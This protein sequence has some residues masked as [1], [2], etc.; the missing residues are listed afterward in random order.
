MS[1]RT[2]RAV[3]AFAV[4]V[5]GVAMACTTAGTSGGETTSSSSGDPGSSSSG[6]ST[7]STGGSSTSQSSGGTTSSSSSGGASSGLII[8]DP[9]PND[10]DNANKDSDCDGLTDEQEYG[11]TYAGGNRT[12]PA[13]PDT[14]GDG[15]LDGVEV[16]ST[17]IVSGDAQACGPFTGDAD[18]ATR[19]IPTEADSEADGVPDGREDLN[20]NGRLDDGET[21]PNNRDSD[22]DGLYDGLEDVNGNGVVDAGETSASL[23]DS[24]ADDIPDGVEDVNRDGT[25]QPTETDPRLADTDGDGLH[26]GDEDLNW[27]HVVDTGETDPLQADT[28]TDQDGIPDARETLLGYDIND[29]DMDDDGLEDGE[30]DRNSNGLVEAN[31]THPRRTDSDCD[32]L[33]DGEEDANHDGQLGADE[34]SPLA[35]DSDGDILRD[36]LE[37]GVTTNPD[38]TNCTSFTADVDPNTTTNARSADTDADGINDGI[39]DV[40]GDGARVDSETDPLNPDTDGD[41]LLDGA[42]DINDNHVVDVG[43]TNPLIPD[44]D[45]DGDGLPDSAEALLGTSPTDTDSDDDGILDGT[46]DKNHDGRVNVGETHPLSKDTDCDGVG[47]GEEDANKNGAVDSGETDPLNDDSDT[48]GITDGVELGKTTNLEPALCPG[49]LAAAQPATITNPLSEDSDGDGVPDGAEDANQNGRLEPGELNPNVNDAG[50]VIGEVCTLA[51]LTPIVFHNTEPEADIQLATLSSFG[52]RTDIIRL[53]NK[54][55]EVVVDTTASAPVVLFAF[56]RAPEADELNANAIA[57]HAQQDLNGVG[58]GVQNPITQALP[59]ANPPADCT[60]DGFPAVLGSYDLQYAG[61]AYDAVNTMIPRLLSGAAAPLTGAMG[62]TGPFKLRMEFVRRSDSRAVIL[63]AIMPLSIYN[64]VNAGYGYRLDD[65][66]NGSAL[67]QVGDDTGVQC[68]VFETQAYPKAD[69][70]FVIDNS[71]SMGDD[72]QALT[73]AADAMLNQ[74]QNAL[75]DWRV[76]RITTDTDSPHDSNQQPVALTYGDPANAPAPPNVDS[77]NAA[78]HHWPFVKPGAG[79]LDFNGASNVVRNYI[80]NP[81]IAGW[82]IEASFEPLRFVLQGNADTAHRLLPATAAGAPEDAWKLRAD[83]RLAVLVVSD[84]GE[85]SNNNARILRNWTEGN[86][87]TILRFMRGG[88]NNGIAL[89]GTPNTATY[90]LARQDEPAILLGGILCPLGYACSGEEGSTADSPL[91]ATYHNTVNALGGVVGSIQQT[92]S[93]APSVQAFMSAVI[94]NASPYR[95]TKAPISASIKVAVEGQ[96]NTG[97]D[98]DNIPRSRINGFDYDGATGQI[99]FYGTCRPSNE[100]ALIGQR[101]AVSYRY[102]IDKTDDP[103]GEPPPCGGQCEAPL[104]CNPTTNQCECPASCGLQNG[105]PAPQVCDTNVNVCACT[106]PADCGG[107]PPSPRLTCNT[108]TCQFTCPQDCGG[109]PPGEGFTC[110]TTTCQYECG[111]CDPADRPTVNSDRYVCDPTTCQWSCPEDCN[112]AS[113][114]PGYRCDRQ[115]CDFTCTADCGGS[116]TGF[117]QCDATS[118]ACECMA[119]ATCGNGYVFDAT[120]CDCVCDVTALSCGDQYTPDADTCSCACKPDCGGICSGGT[121]CNQSTCACDIIPG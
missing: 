13:N 90:D 111:G 39:E 108:Q 73:I 19:T 20:G 38:P 89:A 8:R 59:C 14:D 112:T 67:A 53:G 93:I 48:D 7:G 96:P 71:G 77:A 121:F 54:V 57:V 113:P 26:D 97:C 9:D 107:S 42:E 116:C 105:C 84:A 12:D 80:M 36:G 34:T 82:G 63:G 75:L 23:R 64:D 120:A 115:T 78:R 79:G 118:C 47:D 58:S 95:L 62:V 70:L 87:G 56:W 29:A 100:Q 65:V 25:R 27:N 101:I 72:Q 68:E 5:L 1:R 22:G 49:Y 85:Q 102:W 21:D 106:C 74:L 32:G 98:W 33:R 11:R 86:D 30:E 119:T 114:G 44:T 109:P 91:L 94:G 76:G 24:D 3:P 16:G 43:E 2:S 104:V 35:A 110:N 88:P 83:A 41:G 51:A 66:G 50:G 52:Q 6:S 61:D 15:V 103:N 28:D 69:I 40:N 46:E 37:R 17:S 45:G 4:L 81:G 55:G 31:E 92:D 18:P 10:L 99:T 117:E 60:W